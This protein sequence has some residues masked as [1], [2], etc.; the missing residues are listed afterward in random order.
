MTKPGRVAS[1]G[2]LSLTKGG[3]KLGKHSRKLI[4]SIVIVGLIAALAA[5][6]TQSQTPAQPA[7]NP[8]QQPAATAPPPAAVPA[9]APV[10]HKVG[11]THPF[12]PK[13]L[14]AQIEID[15]YEF[16]FASPE[17]QKNPIFKLPAGKIVGIHI[18]N[19][20]KIV[21]E[22]AIGREV[23]A[24]K[25]GSEYE[26][27]LSEMV[28]SDLFFYYDKVKA[29]IEDAEFGEME[30]EPGIG[31]VWMRITVPEELKGEWEL[32]CFVEGHY[33]QGMKAKLIFE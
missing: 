32:G 16:Y 13:R 29:E 23:K 31:D 21:H 28:P 33:E 9:A 27:V 18:H 1:L 20:G 6:C 30:I 5:A 8:Q 7:S 17:G 4:G 3:N 12:T 22:L 11:G 26:E 24:T 2:I 25:E 15:M 10:A 19:E 14:E